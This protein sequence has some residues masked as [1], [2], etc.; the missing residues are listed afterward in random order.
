VKKIR[1]QKDFFLEKLAL[2]KG[3]ISYINYKGKIVKTRVLAISTFINITIVFPM[4]K[5][6]GIYLFSKFTI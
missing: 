5:I 3:A 4:P 2:E 6:G 1:I